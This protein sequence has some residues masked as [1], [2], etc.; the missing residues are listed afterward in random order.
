M[1]AC[2]KCQGKGGLGTFG[3]VNA[4]HMHWKMNCP[5]CHGS[6]YFHNGESWNM[7]DACKGKGGRGKFGPCEL[8]NMHFVANCLKCGGGG[9]TSAFTP[10]VTTYQ[11]GNQSYAATGYQHPAP[12]SPPPT[13]S[14]AAS[15]YQQPANPYQQPPAQASYASSGYQSP[16][17]VVGMTVHMPGFNVTLGT[18]SFT[19]A[20]PAAPSYHWTAAKNGS[21]PAGAVVGGNEAD[22]N[23]L[24]VARTQ[25]QNG[26]HGGKV[27]SHLGGA[28]CGWG[29]RSHH[30]KDY[31][32]LVAPAHNVRWVSSSGSVPPG[33][34]LTDLVD[35]MPVYVARA[36]HNGGY[37]PG[38][39]YGDYRSCNIAWG[40]DEVVC[41]NCEFLTVV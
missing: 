4:G 19:H 17:P 27:G 31:E 11:G 18:S 3:P 39:T 12:S 34:V 13:Q 21:I 23:A 14:Y 38:K 40:P 6:A 28:Y 29:G 8:T 35:G 24:F 30:F 10:A 15:G 33:A 2:P 7:C 26:R 1:S 9:Y 41:P 32:V 36:F 25:F 20:A 37:H 5:L 16:A 22:G